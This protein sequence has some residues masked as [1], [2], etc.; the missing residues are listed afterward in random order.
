[1]PVTDTDE[2][3]LEEGQ[4]AARQ[5]DGCRSVVIA[6]ANIAGEVVRAYFVCSAGKGSHTVHGAVNGDTW[7][8]ESGTGFWRHDG[9]ELSELN[10]KG[11]STE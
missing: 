2:Q 11:A 4:R 7:W 10:M 1:M 6:D 9:D 3:L 8:R 5:A